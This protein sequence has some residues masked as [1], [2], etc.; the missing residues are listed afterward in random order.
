MKSALD[1]IAACTIFGRNHHPKVYHLKVVAAEYHGYY[2]LSY[3][4]YIAL[5]GGHQVLSVALGTF[6]PRFFE[7]R[8]KQGDGLLHGAG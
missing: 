1:S 3:V 7:I 8:L 6:L 4:V 5:D 2:I